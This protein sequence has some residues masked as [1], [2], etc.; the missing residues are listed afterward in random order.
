MNEER[1]EAL[2]ALEERLGHRF[3]DLAL[4][5]RALTH[6]SYAHEHQ[7]TPQGH[8]ER[9]EFLGDAVLSLVV[10]EMLHRRDPE[11]GEGGKT[12]AR[13]HLVAKPNLTDRAAALGLPDLL[14]MSRREEKT[15]GR[16]KSALWA[17]AY[18]AVLAALYLDGGLE[19]AARFISTEFAADLAAPQLPQPPDYKSA[20]QEFFQARGEPVPEYVTVAEEGPKHRRSWRVQCLIG[21][22]AISEGQG[23]SKKEAQQEAARHALPLVRLREPDR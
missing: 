7:G 16:Q 18:E 6:T 13:A 11:G 10:A 12:K 23:Y 14:L 15:G 8:N 9:L 17:D 20:L 5:D 1:A 22:Q 4:L 2:H 21:G 19:A 3:H